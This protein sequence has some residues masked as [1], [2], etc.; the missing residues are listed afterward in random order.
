VQ[1]ID[2]GYVMEVSIPLRDIM[3]PPIVG[4][5][6]GLNFRIVNDGR[7]L[8]FAQFDDRESWL[9][10]STHLGRLELTD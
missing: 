1:E 5:N 4:A 6:V 8:G 3:L 9:F 7:K 10:D 2:G